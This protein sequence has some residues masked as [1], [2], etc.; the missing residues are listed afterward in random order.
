MPSQQERQRGR[1]AASTGEEYKRLSPAEFIRR[2]SELTGFHN[3]ARAL[4]QTIR[5]LV[6]NSLDA[7]DAKGILPW[8]YIS[9]REMPGAAGV[10]G[11]RSRY[12]VTVED[13]GVG[14]PVS[15][16]A[17]AF[18]KV[19]YSSKYII[20]QTRGM[21]G[22][23]VKAAVLYGQMTVGSPVEVI[24]SVRNSSYTYM[25]RIMIDT[26]KNEPKVV[27]KGEWE[28]KARWHGT[29]VTIML[30]GDWSRSRS[31][32][33][34][35]VRRTAVI[36]PYAEIILETPDG[37]I[38]VYPR[39]TRIMPK[40]PREAKPHPHGVDIEDLKQ[41]IANSKASTLKELLI[42]EF[43]SIGE[44]TAN[45]FL[46]KYGFNPNLNPKK[47]LERGMEG[48]LMKLVDALTEYSFK[49]P[50]S[51]YL[52][53]IGESL[54]KEG[55]RRMFNPEWVEAVTRN[56][57]A[58]KGHPFIV[59][60][61]LAYG[62]SIEPREE[63][64]ILRYANKIPL[65]YSEKEDVIYHVV[66]SINWRNYNV[67]FPAPLI[68]LVHIASTKVPYK[69]MGKESISDVP[70]I[71]NEIKNAVQEVARKLKSYLSRKAREEELARKS[72]TLARYIP[73]VA[74]SLAVLSK[75]P[76]K[77][78][79]P[80]REEVDSIKEM[81]INVVANHL[82]GNSMDREKIRGLIKDIAS[83]VEME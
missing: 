36:A 9:I 20:R 42:T 70:E 15:N 53:P 45:D 76:E 65:L 21:Y 3:P 43:Q 46:S 81:L 55:L 7:S 19:F 27:E 82:A 23:G 16:M 4:Y 2:H 39:T 80:S 28:K 83:S 77:W 38:L 58:Y 71:E 8:I 52:S 61:G 10:N 64:L 12:V 66:N 33:L 6:E 11:G 68:I 79:P 69:G 74:W 50:K 57:R 1:R 24:S 26:S 18:G 34:E 59:E 37:R 44:K 30:E 54:I 47:L 17:E 40:P 67:E 29:R 41:I 14:V 22:L 25:M 72:E 48:M 73:E 5:E 35:Y 56:P 63:P 32:I 49:A 75:P 51:D 62:G 13:N 31:K 60:V 78:A